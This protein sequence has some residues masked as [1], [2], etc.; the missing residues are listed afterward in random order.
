MKLLFV[1]DNVADVELT[2][3]ELRR[4]GFDPVHDR[5]TTLDDL[6]AAIRNEP[7]SAILCDYD[8]EGLDGLDVLDTIRRH[9]REVP[10]LVVSGTVGEEHAVDL[11][12]AGANDYI[13]KDRLHRLGPALE[14]E[15]RDVQ[16]RQ[17]R[18]M[19]FDAF[20]RSEDRYRRIFEKAPVGVV[21]TTAEGKV[22]A[23]NERFATMLGYDREELGGRPM[24]E[25][26]HPDD[27]QNNSLAGRSERRYLRRDGDA[28]WTTVT[29]APITSE[30]STIEQLVWLIEDVTAQ[31]AAIA[32]QK[33]QE[34]ELER[35]AVQ[36]TL[37]A[38]LGQAAL[39]GEGVPAVVAQMAVAV[40]NILGVEICGLVQE[41]GGRFHLAGGIGGNADVV[42]LELTGDSA[43]LAAYAFETRAPAVVT[44]MREER[45]FP[46]SRVLLRQGIISA[47]AVPIS[48]GRV[49]PWGVLGVLSRHPHPFTTGDVDFLRAVAAVLAQAIERDRVDQHL[50]LHAAQQSAIAELS[51]VALR[52]AADAIEIACEIVPR[53]LHVEHVIFYQLDDD[54]RMLRHRAGHSRIA[55][56]RTDV[57]VDSDSWIALALMRDEATMSRADPASA[58]MNGIAAPI[59]AGDFR[60][61]VI[62]ACTQSGRRFSDAD[63]EFL[64]SLAN[65]LAD[66][67]ERER[68]SR[69]LAESEER[70]RGV[71]EGASD[72]IVTLT[73][74]G[75]FVSLNR[76][77]ERI[78][79]WP[80][81]AWIG[82]RLVDLV[83][84]ADAA[85]AREL[86][87]S[88]FQRTDPISTELRVVGRQRELLLDITSFPKLD[89]RRTRTVHAFA[90]DITDVRRAEQ[91]SRE[92]HHKLEQADRLTSL[93]RLAAT[94]A[95]EFNNV[96]MGI[97]PFVDVI[98]RGKGV[99][100]AL[101]H[102][103]R[104]VKRGKRITEDI[105]RFTQPAQPQ[106]AP[107][108]V[109]SWIDQIVFEAR[110]V[111]QS[112]CVIDV[113]LQ[114]R[115]LRVHG[116]ANQLQQMF[117][118]LILNARDAMPR[119]GRLTVSVRRESP[120][121]RFA[122]GIVQHPERFAHFI[123]EDTGSG[124]S[125]ETLRHIFEPLFTTKKS[126][127]GLGLAVAHQI[128]QRHGGDIFVESRLEVGT[129]F[130]IF[131]PLARDG[132]IE[133]VE[134]ERA[135]SSTPRRSV[136]L[137]DDDETVCAALGSLLEMGG[138]HV[139]L[140]SDG[141]S[142][143]RSIRRAL[144]DVVVLDLGLPDMD[145]LS[146]YAAVA[147]I[148]P[149]LPVI[150]SSGHA[151]RSTIEPLLNRPHIAYL[152]K[153]Y[154][155]PALLDAI[156]SVLT[157]DA[158][159]ASGVIHGD[160]RATAASR[161]M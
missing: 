140:A 28:V 72:V 1:E 134:T 75:R 59:S 113:D 121:S 29:V 26:A 74:D 98:R 13:M 34:Q 141:A 12:R 123:V 42:G 84:P 150:F 71:V 40:T 155:L 19:L 131:L 108:D 153:P 122:F 139:D 49:E 77:F 10:I 17:E 24:G 120:G 52:S 147:E 66:A 76:A 93:G 23:V 137:V 81:A 102:I 44:D 82:R 85:R 4:F 124:M 125:D 54:A 160:G 157:G 9:D 79:G 138:H 97:A 7:W 132:V 94:I 27:A 48:T 144:P 39:A 78:T 96:L 156:E 146:V 126:G 90:R 92:L 127:T 161:R 135:G 5:V 100:N 21:T 148:F 56:E 65:V 103:A 152:L 129:A 73:S 37:V 87:M 159:R 143:I 63:L 43:T 11:M 99:D 62:T 3:R 31:N 14:R 36:Q 86:F 105:L 50:V 151:D 68:A 83:H 112:A 95:H 130:H 101:D 35:R 67:M 107:F 114:S 91:E 118:N 110:S 70:Y 25:L 8:L 15:L 41:I 47:V 16:L 60:F 18:R 38:N 128:V 69:A 145:G 109:A 158:A 2:I 142:A 80:A 104:A 88:P 53:V 20:R 106:R 154:E 136:L 89:A 55:A 64:S 116:D 51:R 6:V 45:R 30:D 111:V 33:R 61:G 46:T 117:T 119:G 22:M 149:R 115:D 57:A 133:S 32:E 58:N